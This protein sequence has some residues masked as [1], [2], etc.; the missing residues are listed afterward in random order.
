MLAE[1]DRLALALLGND[2]E[3][4]DT[5]RQTER[6]L[7]RVSQAPVN[8][9]AQNERIDDNGN[10]DGHYAITCQAD[11]SSIVDIT[12]PLNPNVLAF[13]VSNVDGELRNVLWRDVKVWKNWAIVVADTGGI[14]DHGVQIYNFSS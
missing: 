12:D 5:T 14:D 13:I 1:H 8:A 3:L 4:S 9:F 6:R 10:V 11:G 7:D 2:L